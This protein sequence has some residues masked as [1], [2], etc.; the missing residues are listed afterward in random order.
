MCVVGTAALSSGAGPQAVPLHGIK[1]VAETSVP[2]AEVAAAA[3]NGN[4][5][6]N[7]NN[8]ANAASAGTAA[9]GAYFGSHRDPQSNL[10]ELVSV[11]IR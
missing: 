11:D 1:L 2:P 8:G 5:N 9:F 6:G 7:G 10:E 4:Q 3:K